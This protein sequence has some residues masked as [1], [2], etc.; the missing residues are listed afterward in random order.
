MKKFIIM[1]A[2]LMAL[3]SC[4]KE[5]NE[6][7]TDVV[8]G[9]E[10]TFDNGIEAVTL[11]GTP[12][13][14]TKLE[15]T[16]GVFAYK[17]EGNKGQ[18]DL[19]P[20]FMYN[21]PIAYVLGKFTYFPPVYWPISECVNFFAY[22]PYH[23]LSSEFEHPKH[24]LDKGWPEIKYKVKKTVCDQEDYMVSEVLNKDGQDPCVKFH[25][26]HALTKVG[27][28]ANVE[29]LYPGLV[30]KIKSV[31][32]KDVKDT[33]E[34]NYKDYTENVDCWWKNV[35]GC[36]TYNIGLTHPGGVTVAHKIL[37]PTLAD[38]TKVNAANEFLLAMPQSFKH[39]NDAEIEVCYTVENG[40]DCKELTACF[41]LKD[42]QE[43]EPGCCIMYVFKFKLD[44]VEFNAVVQPW[45]DCKEEDLWISGYSEYCNDDC[46]IQHDHNYRH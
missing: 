28:L 34:F 45:K 12:V 1:S 25:F 9:S 31:K 40:G 20:N 42:C 11:K 6:A 3:A 13:E 46:D 44:C 38:Y 22:T 33:G 19:Y 43:W 35:S 10:V 36:E 30:V 17:K 2:A 32:I 21:M 24:L 16:F 14:G 23:L 4:S 27:V 29:G 39:N 41:D 5:Q 7:T 18:Q 26:K 15:Q 37:C 8:A